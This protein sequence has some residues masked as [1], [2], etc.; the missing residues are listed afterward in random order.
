MIEANKIEAKIKNA[1][2]EIFK[3][4]GI[5]VTKIILFGSRARGEWDEASDWDLLIIVNKDL[6]RMEKIEISHLLRKRL[7]EELIPCDVLIKSESEVKKRQNV[8]GSIV[9]TALE[10]GI[11]L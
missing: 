1:I 6:T 4:K 9:K 5:K 7:A 11:N 2:N 10:E 3:E 8:I